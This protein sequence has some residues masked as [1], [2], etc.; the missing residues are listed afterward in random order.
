M[1]LLVFRS[2]VAVVLWWQVHYTPVEMK[3]GPSMRTF[4]KKLTAQRQDK[5]NNNKQLHTPNGAC[6]RIF[7]TIYSIES[8]EIV[9]AH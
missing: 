9:G 8:N 2:V 5:N 6:G 7:I 3:K 1:I 4:E